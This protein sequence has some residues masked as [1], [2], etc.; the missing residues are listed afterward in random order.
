MAELL[1]KASDATNPDPAKDQRGCYKRGDV[2][3][4]RPDGHEWGRLEGLPR[5]VVVKV[6]GVSVAAAESHLESSPTR[7]RTLGISW[8]DLPAG[9]RT[10][11]QTTGT[12]TV[13]PAQIATFIKRKAA[14]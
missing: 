14:T 11:L 9:V 1:V 4:V 5:F 8:A 2:V 12:V 6:P 13:T 3:C 10:Q 7:R